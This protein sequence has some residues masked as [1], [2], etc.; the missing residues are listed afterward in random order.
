MSD[1]LLRAG[2]FVGIIVLGWVL[3]RIGFFKE[4]DFSLLSKI[5]LRITL[6]ASIAVSFATIDLDPSLLVLSA[7]GFG[8]G[9]IYILLA[10]ALNRTNT[11]QQR[12]FDIVNFTSYNIG[13][14]TMPFVQNFVGPMGVVVTSLFDTGNAVICLGGSYGIA[15]SVKD[16]KGFHPARIGKALVTSVPFMAYL[17]MILWNLSGIPVPK[18]VISFAQIIKDANTFIAMLMIGVGFRLSAKGSQLRYIGKVLVLRYTVAVA[19]ALAFY[20]LLPFSLQIRQTLVLLAFSPI[21]SA[22]PA[23]T[24]ELKGD[25]GLSSA[26]NSVCIVCSIVIMVALLSVM[27]F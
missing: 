18:P 12:A 19:L 1:I 20:Y 14:F 8:G 7:L 5:T 17:V 27:Q 25:T 10:F 4:G 26:L 3:R 13:L 23:F 15:S 21:G 2:C 22:A 6:P 11:R 24:Q 16:G 9:V